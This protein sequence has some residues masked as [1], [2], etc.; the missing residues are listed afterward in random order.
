MN[1]LGLTD[2][3]EADLAC[4]GSSFRFQDFRNNCRLEGICDKQA[5]SNLLKMNLTPDEFLL[6]AAGL[7]PIID[8][9]EST[10]EWDAELRQERITLT[11]K[12]TKRSQT[13]V[14]DGSST[15][16]DLLS[17]TTHD[18]NGTLEWSIE[19]KEFKDTFDEN[20][21]ALRAPD[22]TRFT[23][24]ST[25]LKIEIRWED[26]KINPTIN[27]ELFSMTLDASIPSC[28]KRP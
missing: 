8:Y 11:E 6:M 22:K 7:S 20:G 15:H 2:D 13:I 1:A 5:V 17:S 28:H 25:D 27:E 3:V 9:T 23:Q 14:F 18:S 16:W 24:P 4:D 10:L 21:K 12:S 26:R 19:N